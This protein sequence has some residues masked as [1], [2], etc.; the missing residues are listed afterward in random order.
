M[1]FQF[2]RENGY[3]INEH[4]CLVAWDEIHWAVPLMTHPQ[5]EWIKAYKCRNVEP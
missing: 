3:S 4:N 5:S 1:L 2:N